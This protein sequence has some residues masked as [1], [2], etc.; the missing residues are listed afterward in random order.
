MIITSCQ[1]IKMEQKFD[2]SATLSAPKEYPVQVYRG[3]IIAKDYSQSLSSFGDID[4]GWGEEGGTVVIGPDLKNIPDSLEIAWHSFVD[5]K[6][7]EG[8]WALPKEEL[9]KLFN[10]GII[11][12]ITNKKVTYNK[13]VVGLAPN[14]LV[15]VWLSSVR[16]QIEIAHFKAKEVFVNV[17]TISEENKPIFSKKYNDVVLSELNEEHNTFE[18]IKKNEY[19]K[20]DVYE[21][22]RIKYLWKPLV[23]LSENKML[24]NFV[25]HTYNGEI[26]I[27]S[28]NKKEKLNINYEERGVLKYFAF[29]WIDKDQNK[30]VS[31]W[32]EKFDED[33]LFNAY[34]KFNTMEEINF[35][36]QVID[37]SK[38]SIKLKSISQEIEIKKFKVTI[39]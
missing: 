29:G 39:E 32:V 18:R 3:E 17:E 38:I 33:E 30:E 37:K 6:N 22:Y 26:E 12:K 15:V 20:I 31:C 8:K 28:S 1:N 35:I 27:E 13:F 5:Q 24:I 10:E 7:F 36:V 11:N 19:P 14:G 21:G 34:K 4:Y 9:I 25:I 2:W 23:E 16:G